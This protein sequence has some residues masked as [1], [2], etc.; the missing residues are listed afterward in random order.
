[1]FGN[2]IG[3]IYNFNFKCYDINQRTFDYVHWNSK[4]FA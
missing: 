4:S 2:I 3:T 1:L